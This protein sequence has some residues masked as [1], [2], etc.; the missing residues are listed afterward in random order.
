M[1]FRTERSVHIG[2]PL[3]REHL[4]QVLAMLPSD[5]FFYEDAQEHNRPLR[6]TIEDFWGPD[7]TTCYVAPD[8]EA[9][10]LVN[11]GHLDVILISFAGQDA[12]TTFL[13]EARKPVK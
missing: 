12:L 6:E 11:D 5:P 3:S 4:L 8:E 10:L 13:E 2:L 1:L 9:Y 7:A